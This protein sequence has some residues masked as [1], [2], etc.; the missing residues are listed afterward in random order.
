MIQ[1]LSFDHA[2]E[3][4]SNCP[5]VEQAIVYGSYARTECT[6]SS[7]V[8]IAIVLTEDAPKGTYRDLCLACQPEDA[9]LAEVDLHTLPKHWYMGKTSTYF[10]RIRKDGIIFY[11]K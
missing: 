9:T 6:H 4:L 10:E 2:K 3:V 8:D 11:E 7:D 1:D 5:Y